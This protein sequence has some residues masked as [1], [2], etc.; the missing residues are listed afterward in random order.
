MP[1]VE[2][3]ELRAEEA[4]WRATLATNRSD[5]VKRF[6]IQYPQSRYAIS[7]LRWLDEAPA[8]SSINEGGD[9]CPKR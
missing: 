3:A 9:G 2:D 7:A 4:H 5:C 8:G 6:R 1:L